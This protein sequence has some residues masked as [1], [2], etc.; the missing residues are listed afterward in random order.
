[1]LKILK[2]RSHVQNAYLLKLN[3]RTTVGFMIFRPMKVTVFCCNNVTTIEVYD[4]TI[5]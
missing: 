4:S 5:S 3:L 2:D 1:M